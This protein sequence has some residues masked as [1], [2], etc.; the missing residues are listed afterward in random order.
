MDGWIHLGGANPSHGVRK[1]QVLDQQS[2][3]LDQQSRALLVDHGLS[4][5]EIDALIAQ[6][7]V[8]VADTQ[9]A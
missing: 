3:A 8:A 1:C 4:E 5:T 7:A 2:R 9:P 6:G